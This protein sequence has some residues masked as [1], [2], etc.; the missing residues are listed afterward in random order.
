MSKINI[1][2]TALIKSIAENTHLFG[3]PFASLYTDA[4]GNIQHKYL[5]EDDQVLVLKFSGM[6]DYIDQNQNY[7]NDPYY[8]TL[9]VATYIVEDRECLA[10]ENFNI[11]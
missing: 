7:P 6:G 2:K 4:E 1:T 8:D 10:T 9:E 3:H 11:I 5:P